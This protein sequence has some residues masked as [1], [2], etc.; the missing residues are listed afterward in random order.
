[1]PWEM[2]FNF[3]ES[4]GNKIIYLIGS[5]LLDV[6]KIIESDF[7]ICWSRGWL[8]TFSGIHNVLSASNIIKKY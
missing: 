4:V 3:Y 6:I 5:Y 7:S 8:T 2:Y 1:M